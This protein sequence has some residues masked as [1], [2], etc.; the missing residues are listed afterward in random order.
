MG[1]GTHRD[2]QGLFLVDL[3]GYDSFNDWVRGQT[4]LGEIKWRDEWMKQMNEGT[5]KWRNQERVNE[6]TK[7]NAHEDRNDLE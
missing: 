4:N 6:G 7:M 1:V 2:R 3:E 5:C